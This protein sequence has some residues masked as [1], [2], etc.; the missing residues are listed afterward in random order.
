MVGKLGDVVDN[1]YIGMK[2]VVVYVREKVGI[3]E[4][5][6]YDKVDNY[7][8]DEQTFAAALDG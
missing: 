4:I 6:K 2:H 3:L 5:E 7:A 1:M 8:K